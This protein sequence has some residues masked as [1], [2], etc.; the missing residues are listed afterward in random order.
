MVAKDGQSPP[1]FLLDGL[2]LLDQ[3]LPVDLSP[4]ELVPEVEGLVAGQFQHQSLVSSLTTALKHGLEVAA[5][6][7]VTE[8]APG[9]GKLLV[10]LP[11]ISVQDAREPFAQQ[12]LRLL[13][14]PP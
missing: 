12:I 4:L 13:A 8:L 5:E 2:H 9:I 7:G 6:V 14:A 3:A 10:G 11:A 1:E